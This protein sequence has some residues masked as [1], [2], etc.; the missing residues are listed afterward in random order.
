MANDA[1]QAAKV[2]IL[3]HVVT[4]AT[5]HAKQSDTLHHFE[6]A[7]GRGLCANQAC[8]HLHVTRGYLPL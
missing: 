8:L 3:A 7:A 5:K 4:K 6:S 1:R 2:I